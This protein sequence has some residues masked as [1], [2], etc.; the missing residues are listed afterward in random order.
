MR[1]S[2][3]ERR[4]ARI[5]QA[6][7]DRAFSK[8]AVAVAQA[9]DGDAA[10]Y[11]AAQEQGLAFKAFTTGNAALQGPGSFP[12]TAAAQQAGSWSSMGPQAGLIQRVTQNLSSSFNRAPQDLELALAEQGMSWGPPFP[13]GR[14]LDPFFGYRRPPRTFDFEVGENVQL[15]PRNKRISFETLRALY[16][17]YDVAQICVRHLIND[18]RSLEYN[19]EP[20]PG[21]K[22]DVA[23]D[24]EKAIA[25]FDSPD[26]RQ[27]FRM[28]LA[29]F[30]Q[31]VL[32]FDAGSLY[33]RRDE[34]DE[35]LALEV[36]SGTSIIPLID[37][38]GRRPED[39]NDTEDPEG[40]FG[41]EVVPAYLQIIEGLPWD[42]LAADDMI[43][44]PFNPLP[45]SQYG[46]APLEAV[47]LSANTDIRFQWHFLQFFTE[48]TV[49]A[50]FMET[51][52][53][54]SDPSQVQHWQTV[55]DGVMNGEMA[56]KDQI[57]WVPHGSAFTP[58][59]PKSEVFDMEFPLYLMRRTAAAFGVTP[60]D[61]GFTENVNKSSG[62]TQIDVQFRVGTI[63]L[64]RYCEDVINLFTKQYLKL[65]C[66]IH[67]DDGR[68]TED[69]VA[70]AQ[71]QGIYLDHGVISPDEVRQDL[72]YP[73]DKSRPTGRYINNA[74]AGPIPLIAL[75]SMAGEIDEETYGPSDSQ[76]PVNELFSGVPGVV[77]S[78]KSGAGMAAEQR[79][80]ETARQ[81]VQ[82][83]TGEPPVEG[84]R[85]PTL[86]HPKPPEPAPA[87]TPDLLQPE[88]VTKENWESILAA[89]DSLPNDA[90]TI[91][92]VGKGVDNI[93][94]PGVTRG[95]SNPTTITDGSDGITVRTGMGGFDLED[96]DDEDDVEK[97]ALIALAL[98]RWRKNCRSR[99]KKGLSPR[100]FTDDNLP[101]ALHD[102]IF[103]RLKDA[104]SFADIDGAFKAKKASAPLSRG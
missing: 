59:K 73:I 38:Y 71:A 67:F 83:A 3:F 56:K 31:D 23:E 95:F 26:K 29:E 60:N 10:A 42:W 34:T 91:R 99:M 13:P 46:L 63:P 84:E 12:A 25:F 88:E 36:I 15:V 52:P 98:R 85:E 14:P 9:F 53:D 22:A 35:P 2:I 101:Q 96:E 17:N 1:T 19:W 76:E 103:A 74:K 62:D 87:P 82:E 50:G 39:E 43:Y 102:E 72:G 4:R 24:I 30:L 16:E 28:W 66:Q 86:A 97:Q 21:I 11:K 80:E 32:R 47:L 65:R 81:L 51:P 100:K 33:I 70:T 6:A 92:I 89:L 37:F 5:E 93:G 78:P 68:E 104:K 20:I 18:V 64:L 40:L 49:P 45:E 44:L 61:L 7:E 48:G 55:W 75:E 90:S 54:E 77:P 41:G 79:Q 94:G 58:A 27:P 8:A 57:R 69:R